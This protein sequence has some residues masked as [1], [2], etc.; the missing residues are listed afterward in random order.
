MWRVEG[1]N[2]AGTELNNNEPNHFDVSADQTETG[3]TKL[4]KPPVPPF[5]KFKL[6]AIRN[7]VGKKL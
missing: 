7:T 4:K 2:S 1:D 6:R 5:G 3:R